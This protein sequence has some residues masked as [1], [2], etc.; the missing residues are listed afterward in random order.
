M[1]IFDRCMYS[2]LSLK[3]GG[4]NLVLYV[5]NYLDVFD[6]NLNDEMYDLKFEVCTFFLR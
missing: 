1:L 6:I 3:L 5:T 2:F 4:A